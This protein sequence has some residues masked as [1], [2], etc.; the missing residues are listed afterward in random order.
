MRG[1]ASVAPEFGLMRAL[2]CFG[3]LE[4]LVDAR[5]Q[6]TRQ[7]V[8]DNAHVLVLDLWQRTQDGDRR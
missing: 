1:I 3:I 4:F 7:H 8:Y 6:P 5:A 2:I